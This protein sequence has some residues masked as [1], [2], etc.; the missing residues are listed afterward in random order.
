MEK[1]DTLFKQVKTL[2]DQNHI[3][4]F[5]K[6]TKL[7]PVCGFSARVVDVFMQLD[8]PFETVNILESDELRAGMKEFSDWP[9]F[10]QIYIR[11]EFVG[12]CDI[13]MQ[14]FESGELARMCQ[15]Q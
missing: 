11:G 10:P 8:V 6:G 4:L 13:C 9:T 5:I 15:T 2:I 3:V 14:L 7:M 12:G 1:T